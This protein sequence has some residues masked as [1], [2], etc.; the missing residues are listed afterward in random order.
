MQ[1]DSHDSTAGATDTGNTS[2][3]IAWLEAEIRRHNALYWDRQAPEISDTDYDKLV[4]QLRSLAP[5]SLVLTELGEKP[6]EPGREVRHTEPMLSLD[7]CYEASELRAW[8]D[9]FEGSVV[10]MPKYDGIACTLHYNSQGH[11]R[12]AATRG[13]GFVGEDITANAFEIR[14]IPRAITSARALEVRGEI[15]MRLSVFEKYKKEGMAN[16]RNLA[17]G[18]IKLKDSKKSAA[19]DLSF[20]AYDLLSG[21]ESSQSER[22]Q[23]LERLGF[24]KIDA[25]VLDRHDVAKG[26][27]TFAALRPS[28]DYEIDGVVFKANSLREQRRLGQTAHHPR[29]AIAYKFQGESGVSTLLDVEWSVARTGAITPVALV[30]PVVL[31]GVT[32]SRASLHNAAFIAKLGLSRMAKVELVRRGGVIPNVERVVEPGAEAIALPEHCPSCGGPIE[33]KR[34]F[35][36]CTKPNTCRKAVIGQLAHYAATLDILGFGDNVLEHAYDSGLLREPADFYRLTWEQLATR[37]RSGEKSAKKLIAQ[38]DKKRSIP[39]ATFLRALGLPELGK[40]VSSILAAQYRTLDRVLE[41]TRE[42]LQATHGIGDTIAA[43][44]VDGLRDARPLIDALRKVV[45]VE[46]EAADDGS[47]NGPLSGMSFVF[48][49][50]MQE[51]SRSEAEKRVRALGG[52]V[53]SSVSKTLSYLVVGADKSGP[54]SAKEKAA[55]KAIE[56][57]AP[58]R[59]LSESELLALIDASKNATGT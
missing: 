42:Q 18:A 25:F 5:S 13:D 4:R 50:K 58:L 28:L 11:L 39:L 33:R 54:M 7:K 12:V 40:H 15:Y 9:S 16:P 21:E 6:A 3:R 38:I 22:L 30:D 36:Y 48:T 1:R 34:D 52:S 57:G 17:A 23:T 43:S 56:E 51:M 35:L 8:S 10:A 55:T 41:A 2:M 24:P 31:S 49:G 32:V 59:I 29:Y 27:E 37:E 26:F 19:Y 45:T 20:A 44:V 46:P 14:D 53:L 47:T